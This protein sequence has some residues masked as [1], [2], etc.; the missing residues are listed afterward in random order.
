MVARVCVPDT[1][2]GFNGDVPVRHLQCTVPPLRVSCM[3]RSV[4]LSLFY[5]NKEGDEVLGWW[6]KGGPKVKK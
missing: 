4:E 2:R 3:C 6:K 5:Q 1:K